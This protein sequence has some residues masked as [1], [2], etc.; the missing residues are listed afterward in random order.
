MTTLSNN[1]IDVPFPSGIFSF[2]D[3]K[4]A[5]ENSPIF[6]GVNKP[7]D[8]PTNMYLNNLRNLIFLN[9]L[10]RIITFKVPISNRTNNNGI[11]NKANNFIW[12]NEL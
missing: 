10:K 11:A 5:V 7:K 1:K 2:F 6:P 4:Y 8:H 9:G 3:R 12:V